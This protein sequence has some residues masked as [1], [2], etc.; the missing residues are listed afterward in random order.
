[1]AERDGEGSDDRE[2]DAL[3]AKICAEKEAVRNRYLNLIADIIE[4]YQQKA[5]NLYKNYFND[6]AFW[7]YVGSIDDH[8]YKSV[9]YSLVS[10]FLL[11]L[12]DIN[13]THFYTP[14]GENEND[15]NGKAEEIGIEE[16]DCFL[17]PAKVKLPFGAVNLE[18]S[19]ESYKLEAGEGW[20]GKIE[21]DRK[22]GDVTIAFGLGDSIPGVFF[23]NKN[24]GVEF[25]AEAEAKGQFYIT[26]DKG[27]HPTDLGVLWEEEMKLVAGIGEVKVEVGLE[28][29]ALTAGFGSG[30]NMKEGG[31]LKGLIDKMYPVQ[32]DDKQINKKV[33]LYKK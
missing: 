27:G 11:V 30:V 18:I 6:M 1:M 20:V 13:T 22:S 25:G 7:Y 26:F 23:K 8:Q 10:E 15:G 14:C 19:C 9:F 16:P 4:A 28:G 32:P 33:P 12:A 29:D 17:G 31:S 3:V 21:Y 2:Y 24:L 5:I